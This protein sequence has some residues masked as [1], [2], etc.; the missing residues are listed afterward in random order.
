[1]VSKA[2]LARCPFRVVLCELISTDV[3]ATHYRTFIIFGRWRDSDST[4]APAVELAKW[5][6]FPQFPFILLYTFWI[7][8]KK[9]YFSTIV[10]EHQF[11]TELLWDQKANSLWRLMVRKRSQTVSFSLLHYLLLLSKTV[12]LMT[13][14]HKSNLKHASNK[15]SSEEGL[16]GERPKDKSS[17]AHLRHR[18][19]E[20]VIKNW[21]RT[22]K[23]IRKPSGIP[24]LWRH[25]QLSAPL[26]CFPWSLCTAWG[27][28]TQVTTAPNRRIY[29]CLILMDENRG[30]VH[31]SAQA[32]RGIH[33]HSRECLLA[34][35]YCVLSRGAYILKACTLSQLQLLFSFCLVL[36]QNIRSA[37]DLPHYLNLKGR[38]KIKL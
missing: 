37:E 18:E 26:L 25:K 38:I 6:F 32:T 3:P 2:H 22:R 33:M 1:M 19:G 34:C 30:S 31:K 5:S 35:A 16:A 21:E 14:T 8:S 36:W 28:A 9:I 20:V 10:P 23:S 29:S 7:N 12:L 17:A 27:T 11:L 4:Q 13:S 15:C 24:G